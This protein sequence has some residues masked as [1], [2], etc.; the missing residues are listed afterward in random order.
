MITPPATQA[1][2]LAAIDCPLPDGQSPQDPTLTKA[3]LK[4]KMETVLAESVDAN[5]Q[6]ERVIQLLRLERANNFLRGIQNIAPSLDESSSSLFWTQFGSAGTP[7]ANPD[8]TERAFDYNPRLTG[9]Y[10]SKF[11]S[12][13]GERPFYNT[14]AEPAN[15]RSDIDRRGSRQVNLLIEMLHK[16]W[17]VVIHNHNLAFT[18]FNYGTPF[19]YIRPVT[20]GEK[21]GYDD[22]PELQMS[23]DEAGLPAP[24]QVGTN[25]VPRTSV[26]LSIHD[27]Y[28]VTIPFNVPAVPGLPE[29]GWLRSECE[30]DWGTIVSAHP[31][32][33]IILGDDGGGGGGQNGDVSSSTGAVVRAASQSQTGTIRTRNVMLRTY[34]MT[35][36][37]PAR[38]QLIKDADMRAEVLKAFPDGMKITQV[39]GAIIEMKP[40][41][42]TA[43]WSAVPPGMSKYLTADGISWGMFGLEDASSNL[44][45]IAMLFM[46]TGIPNILVNSN[47]VSAD[48]INRT[49]FSP[50]RV[51][52]AIPKSGEDLS[53]AF[54]EFPTSK[55]PEEIPALWGMCKDIM[56]QFYGLLPQVYGQMVPNQT[57]GQA[58]MALTQGLMQLSTIGAMMT[59]FWEQTDTN[60]VK[61]YCEVAGSNPTFQGQTIDLDLIRQAQWTIRGNTT[62][63]RSYAERKETLQEMITQNPDMAKA[64]H[65]TDPVN[66]PELRDY[67]DLPDLKN[68]AADMVESVNDII[69]QLWAGQPTPGPDGA[70]QSSIQFDG[71]IFDPKIAVSCAQSALAER[72]GQAKMATPGYANVRAY[73]QAAQDA[74]DKAAAPQPEA[75]RAT[76]SIAADKLPADQEIAVL[77]KM[78]FQVQAQPPPGPPSSHT[79]SKVTEI[80]AKAAA[81]QREA[82]HK[83]DLDHAVGHAQAMSG[84]VPPPMPG[85]PPPLSSPEPSPGN[86]MGPVQ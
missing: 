55:M 76:V 82:E 8:D 80:D 26:A 2:K 15:P 57:L 21:H 77:Q 32:A 39:E 52:E 41:G 20:D 33:R 81:K 68:P 11:T 51:I 5:Y 84:M 65:V 69:D 66:Y 22:I 46:E 72:T 44:L 3:S 7:V 25:R 17:D 79:V 10:S 56:E 40:Q 53:A 35:W 14:T 19:G 85:A 6:G 70:M 86:P 75:P 34:A 63:P 73:L 59:R 48:A 37:P 9:G 78:G 74:A 23:M 24:V 49:R 4:L 50:N 38:L 28:T 36:L 16:Q 67:L 64:M 1:E 71:L 13:L 62:M 29:S 18:M 42:L 31:N 60:A 45:N 83:A 30:L 58:R 47:Y 43:C 12:V 54:K 27:G 61:M